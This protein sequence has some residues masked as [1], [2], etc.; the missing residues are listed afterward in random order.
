[1]KGYFDMN[2]KEKGK[3]YNPVIRRGNQIP[4]FSFCKGGVLPK[5][6]LF[7]RNPNDKS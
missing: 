7:F 5:Q 3:G 6:T 2:C 1:M 4:D